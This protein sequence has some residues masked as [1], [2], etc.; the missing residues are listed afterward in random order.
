MKLTPVILLPVLILF[1][2]GDN[3]KE[4]NALKNDIL[5]IH[6]KLM[7][8]DDALMQSKTK[9]DSLLKLKTRDSLDLKAIDKQVSDADEA[10]ETWMHQFQP[11]Q[12]GK[13][14]D[15]V[16]KYYSEQKKQIIAVE[17]QMNAAVA[18]AKKYLSTI[19]SK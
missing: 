3:T 2:C 6:D 7:A 13:S 16:M 12:T 9:L 8:C 15:E 17:S 4:E 10:M 18:S 19:K 11:D 1:S 14:H 5:Q